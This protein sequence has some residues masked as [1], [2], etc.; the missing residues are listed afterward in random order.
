MAIIA[1]SIIG[2]VIGGASAVM[3]KIQYDKSVDRMNAQENK[4]EVR[5]KASKTRDQEMAKRQLRQAA[6]EVGKRQLELS[7][8]KRKKTSAMHDAQD[9]KANYAPVDVRPGARP[10]GRPVIG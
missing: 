5:A 10:M 1:I 6:M 3:S 9:S 2:V 8:A 4:A 7:I